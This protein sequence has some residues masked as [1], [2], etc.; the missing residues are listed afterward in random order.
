L[1]GRVVWGGGSA[2]EEVWGVE[3]GEAVCVFVCVCVCVCVC[4]WLTLCVAGS[5][6]G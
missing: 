3:G 2:M 6:V 4:V 1:V 5:V